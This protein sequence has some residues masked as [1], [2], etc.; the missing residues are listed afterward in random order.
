MKQD[1]KLQSLGVTK[2]RGEFVKVTHEEK[3]M[4]GLLHK[5]KG[6][7]KAYDK[8]GNSISTDHYSKEQAVDLIY[9]NHFKK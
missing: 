5:H 9:E 8:D 3:G 1:V 6:N 2:Y 4:I 7:Y